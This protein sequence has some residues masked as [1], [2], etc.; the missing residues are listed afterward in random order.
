MEDV[1]PELLEKCME[2]DWRVVVQATTAER[3]AALD[4][5]L[6]TYRDDSFLPHGASGDAHSSDQPICLT[7]GS[8]NPN[9]STVRFLVELAVADENGPYDRV[10]HIFDGSDDSAVRLAREQWKK[11]K[12]EGHSMTYWQQDDRGKWRKNG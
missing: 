8:D 10:V 12:G 7:T 11:G 3:C 5:H 1:L 9:R 6:W 4:A 2:R